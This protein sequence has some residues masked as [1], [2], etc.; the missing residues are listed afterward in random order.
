MGTLWRRPGKDEE[1]SG[2]FSESEKM[3]YCSED[4]RFTCRDNTLFAIL[5]DWPSDCQ[6]IVKCLAKA[7]PG[8]DPGCCA[9]WKCGRFGMG[10]Y[11]VGIIC[12]AS[13]ERP[14][15]YAY[16][17]KKL[18]LT[19]IFRT[20][21]AVLHQAKRPGAVCY[22]KTWADYDTIISVCYNAYIYG[23]CV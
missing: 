18:F 5:L 21:Q 6:A 20:H 9:S 14:C 2:M 19:I 13:S 16:V 22:G 7:Y 3:T 15:Q 17:L 8:T 4:I 10:A 12:E 23:L 11:A 1:N